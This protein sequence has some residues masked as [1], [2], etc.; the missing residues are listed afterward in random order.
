MCDAATPVQD[1]LFTMRPQKKRKKD[2]PA[3]RPSRRLAEEL[4]A[5]RLTQFR[6]HQHRCEPCH[7]AADRA[8]AKGVKAWTE[9]CLDGLLIFRAFARYRVGIDRGYFP[10]RDLRPAA[11][12]LSPNPQTTLF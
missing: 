10:N 5:E 8:D 9:L 6:A 12:A 7:T 1:P 11:Q 2:N 3:Y 4:C